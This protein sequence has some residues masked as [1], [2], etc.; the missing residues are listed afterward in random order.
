MRADSLHVR[1]AVSDFISQLVQLDNSPQHLLVWE[2]QQRKTRL[3][4]SQTKMAEA[5]CCFLKLLWLAVRESL[6]RETEAGNSTFS[7]KIQQKSAM[8]TS[9]TRGD[10]MEW[11]CFVSAFP[12]CCNKCCGLTNCLKW[13]PRGLWQQM[14]SSISRLGRGGAHYQYWQPSGLVL[15]R[16][17]SLRPIGRTVGERGRFSSC[18]LKHLRNVWNNSERAWVVS[19]EA[20]HYRTL[21]SL[22]FPSV[23]WRVSLSRGIPISRVFSLT[24]IPLVSLQRAETVE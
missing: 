13:K 6:Q 16:I 12:K 24:T 10:V 7:L 9:T 11:T 8:R 14:K 15:G 5:D 3:Q 17:A 18:R 2:D 1:V 4:R 23:C 21:S 19:F 22:L 20:S